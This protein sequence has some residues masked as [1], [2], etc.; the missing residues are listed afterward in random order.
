MKIVEQA[1][2][3]CAATL[4]NKQVSVAFWRQ[5]IRDSRIGTIRH[6]CL[7]QIAGGNGIRSTWPLCHNTACGKPVH[8]FAKANFD[9]GIKR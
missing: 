4:T 9:T 2:R 6:V 7:K 5:L 8:S 3:Q 1:A